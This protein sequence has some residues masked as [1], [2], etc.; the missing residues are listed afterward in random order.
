MHRE[1]QNE[2]HMTAPQM[3]S[4]SKRSSQ[5]IKPILE[6]PEEKSRALAAPHLHGAPKQE[7]IDLSM[8]SRSSGETE[9][10]ICKEK[11]SPPV[12]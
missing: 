10:R 2:A 8:G 4:E 12:A 5:I 9:G 7:E 3:N 11:T 1:G 6:S